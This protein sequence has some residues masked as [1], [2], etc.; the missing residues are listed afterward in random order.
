MNNLLFYDIEVFQEDTLVVFKDI[1][2]KI[3]KSFHNNFDGVK[4]LIS[5]KT[6][7][8]YN[9][10]FYDDFIL[11]AM[12]DGFTPYQIKKLNDE[13]IGGQRKKR[14]H[15][16]IHSLDC[17]Q[18]IDVAKPGLKKIEGNMGKMILESSVDFTIDRKLTE[19]ELEE[20]IDYCSYDV[21]TTIEVFQM[22][23]YNYFNVKDTLIEMLPHNLQSKAHKWN[24]TT[25]SANVLMDKPSPK[26][27]D[28]RLGEYDPEGNYEMLKLVPHEV[29]D[30]WQD[31]E[32]KKKSI[33]IKEF[34]CD[35]QFGFGGLHGVHS[36]RKRFENVKLL[37]VASMYPHIILNLQALGPATNKYHEILNKRIEVKHKDKKLSDALKLV[38]NSVYG[39]LKNQYSLLNNPNAALSVCVYGQ[40]ALYELCKR[41]SPFVTL[42][43]INT[44]GVAFTTSSNEYKTI[45]K[46]WEEDFH[47]TLEEDNFELWIQKDVNNYIALQ[48]GEIKTKGADV[49]RYHSDQLFKNNSIR[50]I[51]ICLVEYLV[52]NQDVLTTIQENLDKPHLFQ[53]ILQAGGTYKGTFDN[54]GKQYNKINRVFASR[55]EGILLQKKRQDDGLV[56]FPD[57]PDNML[58]W[59]DE[60]DKIKN[61][62]QLIDITFYYNLAKQRIE[63][64]E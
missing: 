50:I 40:I 3:V 25:I 34:D 30:I 56:R 13:I 43:N 20:I 64:W 55:K 6:L 49:S 45:W 11:T 24:T 35:I 9:N 57:T 52:N 48:N 7:V 47:L 16:A 26:W 60:C 58:V 61:F 5:E 29:V 8:G 51:D 1:D 27:S 42:V 53:Y 14:I 36:T 22:R 28:I 39:N 4:D 15:P 32:Q 21:D 37:D 38:L 44:D 10:H 46:E 59:N 41:L 2:K 63:R 62:S 23:E 12:L 33:T 17:F 31:K 18:Q 19:E 54:N